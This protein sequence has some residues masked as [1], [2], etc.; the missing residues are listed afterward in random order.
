MELSSAI[1]ALVADPQ[2]LA[3]L[4][5]YDILDTPAEEGFD[6]IVRLA[7]LVCETPVALVSLV[8]G[9]R[10]WFKARIGFPPCE[11]DLNSSVCAHALAEPDVLIITDLTVDPRTKRNPLVT[12]EPHIRFY[13]GAPLRTKDGHTLGSLC[14]IDGRPRPEGLSAKQIEGLQALAGQVV[15]QLEL[16]RL[17]RQQQRTQA[18]LE[19]KT[20]Q[21]A[22]SEDYWR[23]LFE[24]LR[25]G[26]V[27]GQLIKD[28]NGRVTD[29]RYLEIN[30]AWGEL[31]GLPAAEAIGRTVREVLPEI[32]DEWISEPGYVVETGETATFT[33]Q[34]GQLGR[35]L[36]GRISPLGAD[37]FV[38]LFLDVTERVLIDKALAGS[39][40]RRTALARLGDTLRKAMDVDAMGFTAGAI[41]GPELGAAQ[42]GYASIDAGNETVKVGPTWCA[43][44]TTSVAGMHS[45][46]D[47]GTYIEELK[48]GRVVVVS[49][50][51]TDARTR[52]QALGAFG[53]SAFVNVPVVEHGELVGML[54]VL[55]AAPRAVTKEEEDFLRAAVDR[56]R[57]EVARIRAEEQQGILNNEIS[58]RLKNSMAM[59]QAIANQTLKG[60]ADR[61]PVDSFEQRLMALSTAHDVLLRKDWETADLHEVLQRVLDAAGAGGRYVATG[62]A[63]SL[64]P[65]AALSTS[66]LL[67]EL[68][69][70][71]SK[72]GALSHNAGRVDVSWRLDGE[73]NA[74]ELVLDWRET[75]GP[76]AVEPTRKGFG[77]RLLRMGLMGTGGS[78]IAYRE[79]GLEASFRAPR[80]QVEKA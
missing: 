46:R 32:A 34:L 80:N 44:G 74:D 42:A 6:E 7:G 22:A 58:H 1:P 45:F 15:R 60:V 18:M 70:N 39:A 47:Y 49:D 76:P 29:W 23:G 9:D 68:A 59:I 35:W 69:T 41:V 3:A 5:S 55:F 40:S 43:P 63:T 20:E 48:A 78:H 38:I 54:L 51:S 19:A 77:S 16:H 11:T 17:V 64:G 75:G 56:T 28:P 61:G 8:S 53:I 52:G 33:R 14:V 66:L 67:H 65:R 50:V 30:P 62:P 10:Q 71:A 37:T 73:V 27:V 2:R 72:Y 79:T 57:A 12:G 31:T 26:F 36:E 13:A 25:E 24:R 4:E 21:L